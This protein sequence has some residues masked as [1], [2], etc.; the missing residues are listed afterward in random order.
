M[1]WS[2][3][4]VRGKRN[5]RPA[6]ITKSH[7][8]FLEFL[9]P[10]ASK[11][12]GVKKLGDILGIPQEEILVIGDSWNDRELFT[13]AALRSPWAMPWHLKGVGHLGGSGYDEDGWAKAMA[14]WVF[15]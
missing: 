3:F 11:G 1:C 2:S 5:S 9:N 15:P 14:K 12:V 10:V 8:P 6:Y 4:G 7:T 13:A